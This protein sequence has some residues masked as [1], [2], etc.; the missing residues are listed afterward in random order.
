[1]R[2]ERHNIINNDCSYSNKNFML[3]ILSNDEVD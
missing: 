1:M 3:M 2:S